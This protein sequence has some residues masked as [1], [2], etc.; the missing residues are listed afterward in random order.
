MI[1]GGWPFVFVAYGVSLGALIVLVAVVVA[2]LLHWSAAA[3]AL[4]QAKRERV[5]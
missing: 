1:E 3:R 5:E 2:R 4:D